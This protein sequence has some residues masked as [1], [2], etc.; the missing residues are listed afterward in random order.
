VTKAEK[1]SNKE[2]G[3]NRNTENDRKKQNKN[4]E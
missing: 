2:M 3:K 1:R 4:T